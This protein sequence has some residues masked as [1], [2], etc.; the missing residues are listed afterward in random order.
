VVLHGGL[1][2]IG[3][4]EPL[5]TALAE[6]RQVMAVELEGHGYTPLRGEPLSFE[7]MADDAAALIE[8]LGIQQADLCGYSHGGGVAW[9]VAIRHPERVRKLIA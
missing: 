9:Q 6:S 7:Q 8:Q 1:M 3:L 2:T 5:V 4:M